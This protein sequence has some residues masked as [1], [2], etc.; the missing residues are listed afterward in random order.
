MASQE[1]GSYDQ[2]SSLHG[3]APAAGPRH[4]EQKLRIRSVSPCA[5]LHLFGS[6]VCLPYSLASIRERTFHT[7]GGT[8]PPIRHHTSMTQGF[9]PSGTTQEHSLTGTT[10]GSAV[11]KYPATHPLAPAWLSKFA[12]YN[13]E[14][15]STVV[16]SRCWHY[17]MSSM[18]P[19]LVYA[20]Y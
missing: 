14:R 7:T 9:A 17:R 12:G 2:P 6:H 18:W 5:Q 13:G 19:M 11:S 20:R 8:R 3:T 16:E 10:S 4:A 15:N 1:E